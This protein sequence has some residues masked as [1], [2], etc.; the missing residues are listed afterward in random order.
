MGLRDSAAPPPPTA[1][2]A[3]APPAPA[4]ARA[5]AR[6][7]PLDVTLEGALAE[8][9]VARPPLVPRVWRMSRSGDGMCAQWGSV[10]GAGNGI[11]VRG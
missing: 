10:A 9:M 4:E 3:A 2:A 1:A 11:G 7:A 5:Q 6:A 8:G